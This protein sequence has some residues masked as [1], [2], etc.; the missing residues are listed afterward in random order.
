M[1]LDYTG[2]I[3]LITGGTTGIGASI[4]NEFLKKGARVIAVSRHNNQK[5]KKIRNY[6]FIKTDLALLSEVNELLIT[7]SKKYGHVDILINN[8]AYNPPEFENFLKIPLLSWE[9]AVKINLTSA[10]YLTQQFAK[11]MISNQI[12]GNIIFIG[13]L[14]TNS[15]RHL[16]HYSASKAGLYMV[17]REAAKILAPY[18]IRVNMIS[19]GSVNSLLIDRREND[20]RIPIKFRG[21][22][23]DISRF[24]LVLCNNYYSEY[25]V[26]SN[27]I[28]DGGLS[29]VNWMDIP[30]G[31]SL[32]K[33]SKTLN[34][35]TVYKIYGKSGAYIYITNN[36]LSRLGITPSIIPTIN[37]KDILNEKAIYHLH[38]PEELYR[39]SKYLISLLY[40]FL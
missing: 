33:E 29:L 1:N 28:I 18:G 31:P 2:K 10:F 15:V 7:I 4:T 27:I 13:S 36:A 35:K 21:L 19:P 40:G 34:V 3:V 16:P 5:F 32:M 23:S 20:K 14:H 11:L 6:E 39:N 9:N 17:M 8:A 30:F 25:I 22:A 24:L 37:L 26:G 38:F 12:K